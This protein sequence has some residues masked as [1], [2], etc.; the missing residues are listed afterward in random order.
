MLNFS[1]MHMTEQYDACDDSMLKAIGDEQLPYFK[2][3]ADFRGDN[4]EDSS[5]IVNRAL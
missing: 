2:D 5:E 3:L 1:N 4:S